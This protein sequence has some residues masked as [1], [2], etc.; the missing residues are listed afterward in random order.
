MIMGVCVLPRRMG[1]IIGPEE[2]SRNLLLRKKKD[3]YIM[4]YKDFSLW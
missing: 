3:P 1:T 4:K 2:R